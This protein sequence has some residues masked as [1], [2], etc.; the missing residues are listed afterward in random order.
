MLCQSQP[1]F[2]GLDPEVV[3]PTLSGN[4]LLGLSYRPQTALL[5]LDLDSNLLKIKIS[6]TL[7]VI[8]GLTEKNSTEDNIRLSKIDFLYIS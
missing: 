6:G 8:A 5:S 1:R 7:I 3:I 4:K 2:A